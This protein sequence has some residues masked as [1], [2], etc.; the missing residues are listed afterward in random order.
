MVRGVERRVIFRCRADYED[1]LAR[2]G[3]LVRELGFVVL[4]W[5]LIENHAHFLL[6]VGSV[7]LGV[8][9]ARLNSRHALR[10]NRTNARVGHLF[11]G[12]YK[13]VLI[14]DERGVACCAAYVLGNA[15]RHLVV[16]PERAD[17]YPWS[18]QGALV[19]RRPAMPFESVQAT[20][21]ALGIERSEVGSFIRREAIAPVGAG[22][23]LEPDQIDE[24]DRLIVAACA[25]HGV[26]AR[27]LAAAHHA[28]RAARA[29][30]CVRAT[31][32]L[33]LRL[34]EIARRLGISYAA[35]R[36]LVVPEQSGSGTDC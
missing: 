9:M 20:A 19:G 21:R 10:F 18:G 2:F 5:C 34:T 1:Y 16:R 22:A 25:R 15:I 11:Q 6:Q 29:E 3:L 30:I 4:A 36:L 31:S 17:D 12:R 33:D 14:E 32:S 23:A 27:S 28:A 35:A 24:L 26:D 7:P 8:L 13:A